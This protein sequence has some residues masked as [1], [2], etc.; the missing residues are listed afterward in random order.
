MNAAALALLLLAL[1]GALAIALALQ[2]RQRNA[3][4]DWLIAPDLHPLPDGRGVWY[5]IF[6][7][8]RK[9]RKQEQ[10]RRAELGNALERF[11]LAVQSLP[12]GVML[13]DTQMHIEWL[14]DAACRQFALDAVRDPGTLAVQLIRQSEFRQLIDSYRARP[15]KQST[16]L[17]AGSNGEER[18]LSVTLLPFAATGTL[19][20]AT[21]VTE[22]VRSELG[23]RDFIAN[24][25]HELRTPLTVITGFLEQFNGDDPPTGEMARRFHRLMAEQA[26][27][28]NRLIA[29]LLTLS[30]LESSGQPP[31]DEVIDV[32]A[33]LETLR[34]EAL[35][36]SAG[37]HAIDI[38]DSSAGKLRGSADELRSAFGNLVFNAVRYT[39]AGGKITMAWRLID[40]QPTF[41]VTDTGIG[42]PPEHIPRLTE[43]FYRV[44]KGRSTA[45]GGTGLGLAI[46]KH[47][48]VRHGGMLIIDSVPGKGSIFTVA[49][50]ADRRA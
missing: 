25:S 45:V 19:L 43:R 40:G 33:L 18:V 17:R 28:M 44:D 15:V 27:R 37:R 9:T 1:A 30:S 4:R 16:L 39:P 47:V 41:A 13:L 34:N 46:V 35:A 23:Q 24:V 7:R 3:L 2:I 12:E 42:I 32:P 26:E 50:P 49:L 38:T 48:L 10:L 36:L 31:R 29:D 20:V 5:E 22:Q 21:D 8:L 11:R 6:S 14:N